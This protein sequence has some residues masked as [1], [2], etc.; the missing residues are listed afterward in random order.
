[1]GALGSVLPGARSLDRAG[2]ATFVN[3]HTLERLRRQEDSM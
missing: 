1:M 3:L 2:S